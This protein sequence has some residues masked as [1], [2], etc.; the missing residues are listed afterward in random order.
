MQ[1][2]MDG[3]IDEVVFLLQA[4]YECAESLKATST[5]IQSLINAEKFRQAHE[6]LNSRGE[7]I[8]LMVSLDHQLGGLMEQRQLVSDDPQ[9]KAI[10]G[11]ATKLRELMNSILSMDMVSQTRLNR[12]C[13]YIGKKLTELQNGKKLIQSYACR[14]EASHHPLCRA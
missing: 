1:T 4:E 12:H 8:D 10:E 13:E 7:I 3:L 2:E 9:W 14:I 11:L 5:E 6:R